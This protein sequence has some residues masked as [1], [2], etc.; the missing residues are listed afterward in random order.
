LVEA[1]KNR[2]TWVWRCRP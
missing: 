1:N 2:N